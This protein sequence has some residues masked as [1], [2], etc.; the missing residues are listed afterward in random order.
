MN[1]HEIR[2]ELV[3]V[4]SSFAAVARELRVTGTAV[5]YT[6]NRHSP[7]RRIAEALSK[8]INKPLEVVFPEYK[9]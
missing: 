6:A 1:K 7:S 4:R 5:Q 9:K 8:K 3:K 2:G